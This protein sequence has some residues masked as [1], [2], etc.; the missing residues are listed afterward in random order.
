MSEEVRKLFRVKGRSTEQS[1]APGSSIG[2][3]S[4]AAS[5]RNIFQQCIN[6]RRSSSSSSSPTLP[7]HHHENVHS[8]SNQGALSLTCIECRKMKPMEP[9]PPK[10]KLPPRPATVTCSAVRPD[11][12]CKALPH[13]G[14]LHVA[15][16]MSGHLGQ[17]EEEEITRAK[18]VP[19][20]AT[21]SS[22]SLPDS[23]SSE[24]CSSESSQCNVNSS[25]KR[26]CPLSS[27]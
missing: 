24:R 1:S 12:S 3:S 6:Y 4:T 9:L 21:L 11:T 23:E 25:R 15:S 5:K 17:A 7:S 10:P 27:G 20:L 13:M 19:P 2:T 16:Q 8:T 22:T 18:S 26:E 14:A